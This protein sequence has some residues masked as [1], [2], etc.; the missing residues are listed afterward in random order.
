MSSGSWAYGMLKMSASQPASSSSLAHALE[1]GL[2]L[3]L[4]GGDDRGAEPGLGDLAEVAPEPLAVALEHADEVPDAVGVAEEVRRVG[5]LGDH[6]ERLLLA[7][8][9]DHDRDVSADR[10]R[11]VERLADGVVFALVAG[12]LLGEHGAGD[13]ERVLE[14]LEALAESAEAE[15]VGP[16]LGLEPGGPKTVDGPAG[17]DRGERGCRLGVG[18]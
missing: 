16:V 2:R 15:V 13:V 18:C 9:A 17:G 3:G 8:A 1:L 10:L 4:R 12:P 5:V 7:A 11:V 6:A 14:P